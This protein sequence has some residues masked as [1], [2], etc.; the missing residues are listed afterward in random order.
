M[1]VVAVLRHFNEVS[2]GAND[3]VGMM[4]EV[5]GFPVSSTCRTYFECKTQVQQ[6]F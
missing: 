3:S 1:V 2:V 5:Y 4:V 6:N